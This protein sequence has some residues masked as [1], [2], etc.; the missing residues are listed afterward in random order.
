LNRRAHIIVTGRV[1]GVGF[2][3]FTRTEA[4]A[5]RLTGWVRN[6]ADGKVEI[7]AQGESPDIDQFVLALSR[8]PSWASV[9]NVSVSWIDTKNENSFEVTG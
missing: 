5:L 8:G 1:Q 6:R 2:R 4:S 7:E 3:Y 9:D